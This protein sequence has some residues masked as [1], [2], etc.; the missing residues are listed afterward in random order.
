MGGGSQYAPGML[1]TP[2]ED[3]TF[4]FFFFFIITLAFQPNS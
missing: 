3:V 1:F 2:I 4:F